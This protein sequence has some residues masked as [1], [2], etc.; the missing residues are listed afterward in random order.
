[1]AKRSEKW[2]REEREGGRRG[3]G[4]ADI[5]WQSDQMRVVVKGEERSRLN[6]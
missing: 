5:N 1:M 4:E 3:G 2:R 6:G